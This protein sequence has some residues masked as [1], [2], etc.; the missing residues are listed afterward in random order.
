MRDNL[1]LE[2]GECKSRN[3]V[4]SRELRRGEKLVLKKYCR[5]CPK[6]TPHKERKT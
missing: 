3:Y 5:S 4:T 6:H 2:C 1:L